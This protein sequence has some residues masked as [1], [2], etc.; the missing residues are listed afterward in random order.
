MIWR[1]NEKKE[2]KKREVLYAPLKGRYISLEEI[3]DPVFAEGIMGKGC[4]IRPQ[5]GVLVSPVDGKVVSVAETGHAIGILSDKGAELLLHVG[6]DTVEMSG[7]GFKVQVAEGERVTR[8]QRL[9][10]FEPEAIRAGG[11]S[12]VTAFVI[13]NSDEYTK[14]SFRTGAAYQSSEECGLLER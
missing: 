11:F 14:V 2:E 4:G 8:G 1:K 7:R 13:T 3:P 12:D 9:L 6:I 5:E 10:L